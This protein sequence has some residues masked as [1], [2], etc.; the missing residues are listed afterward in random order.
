MC[1][2]SD[3]KA[4]ARCRVVHYCGAGHQKEDHKLHRALCSARGKSTADFLTQR[5]KWLYNSAKW[6]TN[7][8]PADTQFH[9]DVCYAT[10]GN[11]G[12][13]LAERDGTDTAICD[14]CWFNYSSRPAAERHISSCNV[15]AAYLMGK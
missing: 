4:C 1:D 12:H 3:A 5:A 6:P 8:D 7:F 2:A 10:G 9:C 11:G 15:A 14:V 13:R